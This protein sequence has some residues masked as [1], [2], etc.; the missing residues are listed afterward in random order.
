MP[1]LRVQSWR[2]K[3]SEHPR[4]SRGA[5]DQGLTRLHPERLPLTM[6]DQSQNGPHPLRSRLG[7]RN[8]YLVGMMGSGKSSSGRPLAKQLGYGFVDADPVIEQVAGRPIPKIFAEEGE[9]GFRA[10]ESQVLQAIGQRHSL[11]VATGGG[12]VTRPENWGILHQGVVIWLAPDR[13][14]ILKRLANDP[15]QRPLLETDDP[16]ASLDALLSKRNPFYAEADLHLSVGDQ[17]AEEVAAMVLE[18]IPTI[19]SS[20]QE[21]PDGPQT[22]EG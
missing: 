11:V 14:R 18:A 9:A 21:A 4:E 20:N 10:I 12:V 13:E 22:T 8:L 3:S 16:T 1:Q 17:S 6:T 15:T 5:T 7:G 2:G 19:L